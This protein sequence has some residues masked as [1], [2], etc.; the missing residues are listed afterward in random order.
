MD[1]GWRADR[2]RDS[3]Y[4]TVHGFVAWYA[5]EAAFAKVWEEVCHV[6][7]AVADLRRE[8]GRM[9]TGAVERQLVRASRSGH[10]RKFSAAEADLAARALA[11]MVDRFCYVTYVFDPPAAGPPDPADAAALLPDLWASAVRLDE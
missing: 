11:G 10:T 4:E 1:L 8:V 2:G 6:D 7:P 5:E 9:F 3:L